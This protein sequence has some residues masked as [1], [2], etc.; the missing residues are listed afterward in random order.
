MGLHSNPHRLM[1]LAK[2]LAEAGD[3]EWAKEVY[4]EVDD[5]ARVSFLNALRESG[6]TPFLADW[7]SIPWTSIHTF[8]GL[9]T[10]AP[11][12]RRRYFGDLLNLANS[13]CKTLGDKEWAKKVY[14]K[15]EEIAEDDENA[16]LSKEIYN[17]LDDREWGRKV[18]YKSPRSMQLWR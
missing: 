15:A 10:V 2:Y 16:T 8:T 1:D 11:V 12:A 13:L 4:E 17:Y 6:L 7:T 18:Y 9:K 14:K 3:T 5:K